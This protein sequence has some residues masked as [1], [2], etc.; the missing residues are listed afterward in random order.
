[1]TKTLSKRSTVITVLIQ[2]YMWT[3][4]WPQH[5]S[6]KVCVQVFSLCLHGFSVTA[7][8]TVFPQSV[9]GTAS[10]C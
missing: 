6:Q 1:M 7:V 3:N 10:K 9:D 2:G 5:K 4:L 8:S